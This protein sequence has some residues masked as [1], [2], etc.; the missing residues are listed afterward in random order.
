MVFSGSDDLS[1]A[2]PATRKAAAQQRLAEALRANLGRRK[3]QQRE[4]R[5]EAELAAESKA[6]RGEAAENGTGTTASSRR[7]E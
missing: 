3:A 6:Y 5:R 7:K 2:A 4:Q 1:S